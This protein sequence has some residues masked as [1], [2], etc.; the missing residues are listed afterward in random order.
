MFQDYTQRFVLRVPDEDV[1]GYV[2]EL[3]GPSAC[4]KVVMQGL[5]WTKV[6]ASAH[7]RP[8]ENH[9]TASKALIRK[10]RRCRSYFLWP[11]LKLWV[12]L[13][14]VVSEYHAKMLVQDVFLFNPSGRVPD[15]SCFRTT[16]AYHIILYERIANL[17]EPFWI[18]S[19]MAERGYSSYMLLEVLLTHSERILSLNRWLVTQFLDFRFQAP[20]LGSFFPWIWQS[21][22]TSSGLFQ[23]R[24]ASDCFDKASSTIFPEGSRYVLRKGLPLQSCCG[25]GIKPSI[26]L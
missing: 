5:F 1:V 12:S 14:S 13:S 26:L 2:S 3:F 15:C 9:D 11:G 8:M 23:R 4:S 10:S 18:K 16:L 19:C 25:D 6:T 22:P 7:H 21:N 24:K 17:S 20:K